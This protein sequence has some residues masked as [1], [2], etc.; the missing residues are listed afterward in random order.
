M[1]SGAQEGKT[2]LCYERDEQ[3]SDHHKA[4]RAVSDQRTVDPDPAA[5]RV[6]SQHVL[7]VPGQGEPVPRDG[8]PV[9][10]RSALPYLSMALLH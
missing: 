3:G 6:Y 10:R 4:E 5:Q 7:R 2:S 9:G 8:L 1:A